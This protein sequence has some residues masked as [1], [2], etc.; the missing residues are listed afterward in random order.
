MSGWR[1]LWGVWVQHGEATVPL[2]G[3]TST[4]GMTGTIVVV[5]LTVI[6]SHLHCAIW[7]PSHR[8]DV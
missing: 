6:A 4:D 1:L 7:A 8:T 2:V 3:E 5:I